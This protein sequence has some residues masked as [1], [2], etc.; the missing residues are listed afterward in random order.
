MKYTVTHPPHAVGHALCTM[1]L[2][3]LAVDA[4][5][6]QTPHPPSQ[7]APSSVASTASTVTPDATNGIDAT[8]VATQEYLKTG[9]VRAVRAGDFL[10][11]PYG[12]SQP[13]LTCAPLRTCLIRLQPE[14]TVLGPPALGDSE[15]WIAG[16]MASGPGGGTPLIYVKPTACD[17]TTDLVIATDRHLY[18][19]TLDAPPCRTT[20][21]NS[22]QT[23][24]TVH[25]TFY[26]PDETAQQWAAHRQ[27]QTASRVN[28]VPLTTAPAGVAPDELHFAYD[29]HKD[30]HF[31]WA[32]EQVFDD[33]AHL[34]VKRPLRAANAAAPI[35]LAVT[36]DGQRM[37][38]NYTLRRDFYITDRVVDQVVFV[39]NDG[40]KERRLTITRTGEAR[41]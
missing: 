33:G 16:L 30:R 13:T 36:A 7:D 20:G 18:T 5:S 35:L 40:S 28:D 41:R 10:A 25:L 19:V 14:E 17:I 32:P 21:T 34:Y 39:I 12:R 24:Y 29:V 6:A 37:M 27:T 2:I 31:P 23:P 15:R 4:T 26:Y 3:L 11:V 38:L 9:H 1:M 22:P 8:V